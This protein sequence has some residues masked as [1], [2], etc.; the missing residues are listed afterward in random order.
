MPGFITECHWPP[1]WIGRITSLTHTHTHNSRLVHERC[2]ASQPHTHTRQVQRRILSNARGW[3]K[4]MK[5]STRSTSKRDG[6]WTE[7]DFWKRLRD[8]SRNS[9]ETKNAASASGRFQLH[10]NDCLSVNEYLLQLF[11]YSFVVACLIEI[12]NRFVVYFMNN[13]YSSANV[14]SFLFESCG[15]LNAMRGEIRI[16]AIRYMRAI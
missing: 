3:S 10:T 6:Q 15:K 16:D 13:K 7:R 11:I 8:A 9:R 5:N 14:L 4:R 12:I 1:A 2:I